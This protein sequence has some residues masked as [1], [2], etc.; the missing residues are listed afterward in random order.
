M[1]ALTSALPA[2]PFFYLLD[3]GILKK[4]SASWIRWLRS[5][6]S[7][8]G[9]LLCSCRHSRLSYDYQFINKRMLGPKL[10]CLK[11]ESKIDQVI[12]LGCCNLKFDAILKAEHPFL[13]L[14]QEDKRRLCLQ[15]VLQCDRENRE[16][17]KYFRNVYCLIINQSKDQDMRASHKTTN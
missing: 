3:F 8:R 5:W 16:H 2:V 12:S 6:F 9:I 17:V 13:L 4:D 7:M 1:S 11:R 15:V 10:T 14:V